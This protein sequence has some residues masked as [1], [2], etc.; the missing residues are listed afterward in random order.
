MDAVFWG[1]LVKR[2]ML[3]LQHG[4]ACSSG[5]NSVWDFHGFPFP[6]VSVI[7]SWKVLTSGSKPTIYKLGLDSLNICRRLFSDLFAS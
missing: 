3:F 1:T 7:F 4:D 6:S 5:D 2:S